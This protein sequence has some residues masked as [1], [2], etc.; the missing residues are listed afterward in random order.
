[1]I[2]YQLTFYREMFSAPLL[3][4]VSKNFDV[5]VNLRR[6]LLSEDGG[7]AE[8]GFEGDMVEVGRAVA[9]LQTTGVTLNGPLT[10][11]A[12]AHTPATVATL[13]RGT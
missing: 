6:A 1:V 7:W 10:E 11:T 3:S 12:E 2:V 4:R 9:Y 13:S 8:V 5:T